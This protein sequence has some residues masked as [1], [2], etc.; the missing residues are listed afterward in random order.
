MQIFPEMASTTPETGI[1]TPESPSDFKTLRA[2]IFGNPKNKSVK[3]SKNPAVEEMPS[4]KDL[5]ELFQGENWEAISSMYFDARFAI[6]GWD[7]FLLDTAQKKTLGMTL[8]KSMKMLLKIDPGYIALTVFVTTFGG[9]IAQKEL[10]YSHLRKQES[11]RGSGTK[12]S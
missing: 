12:P 8:G 2:K 3:R 5:E 11:K 7:G 1:E 4:E 6:T 9:L 10:T